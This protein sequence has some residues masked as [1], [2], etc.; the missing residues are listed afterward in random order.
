M[1]SISTSNI[2]KINKNLSFGYSFK[3]LLEK[4]HVDKVLRDFKK[5]LKSITQIGLRIA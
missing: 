2:D 4:I 5:K 3:I 1:F